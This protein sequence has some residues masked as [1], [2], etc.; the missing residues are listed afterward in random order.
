MTKL[1]VLYQ[2]WADS[3]LCDCVRPHWDLFTGLPKPDDKVCDREIAWRRYCQERGD[4]VEK[5]FRAIEADRTKM[6]QPAGAIQ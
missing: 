1:Q 5:D 4:V 2:Q 3:P 6:G